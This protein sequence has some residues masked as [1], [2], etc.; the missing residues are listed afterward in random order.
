MNR[1]IGIAHLTKRFGEATILEDFSLSLPCRGLVCVLGPSGCGKSTLLNIVAG[2]DT[3]YQGTVRVL[4]KEWRKLTPSR[5]GT[6]RLR[7]IGYV[8]QNFSLLELES[9]EANVYAVADALYHSK[10]QDK[11]RKVMDLLA[12]FG[13]EGK[14][15]QKVNTLSGGEKQRVALARALVSDPKIILADEPTGALDQKRGHEVFSLLQAC[16]KDRLVIIVT[17]DEELAE[18]YADEMVCL[19]DGKITERRTMLR[20]EKGPSPKSFLLTS[21]KT[22]PRLSWNFLFGHAVRLFRAKKWRSLISEGA[23]SLGLSGLGIATYISTSIS[24]ELSDAFSSL[25]PPNTVVM[26]PRGGSDSPVGAVYGAGIDDCEYIVGEY[27]DLVR[28]YGSDLH[29]DYEGWFVDRN[30]FSYQSGVE[31]VR[32]P[33]FSIRSINDYRWLDLYPSLVCYPRKPA[34]L[35][36]DQV[37]LGLPYENMFTMCLSL[38]I[39]RDYQSLGEYIDTHRLDLCLSIA[40]YAIGFDDE[41][42][43]RVVAV[44]ESPVPCFYHY[45]HHWNHH[46]IIDQ[47]HFRSSLSEDVPNPQYV[48]EIPFVSVQGAKEEFLSLARRDPALNHLVYEKENAGYSPTIFRDAS[49]DSD[50]I[51]LYGCDKSGVSFQTLDECMDLCPDILGR[52]PVTTGSYFAQTG[53]LAM[54]FSNLFFLCKDPS[55]VDEVMDAYSDL[56]LES[57]FLPGDEIAGSKSG[58]C[59]SLGNGLRL[60]SLSKNDA[61]APNGIEECVLTSGLYERWGRPKE[62]FVVA[63]IGAEEVGSSYVRNLASAPMKVVGTVDRDYDTLYVCDDWTVDFYFAQLGVSS[64]VLEPYGAVF[65]LAEGAEA[66]QSVTKLEK[67][68][69]SYE[70]TN[71]SEDIASSIETTLGYVGTILL[72]FSFIALAMSALL[73]LIVMT[74]TISESQRDIGLFCILGLSESDVRNSFIAQCV[75]YGFFAGVSSVFMVLA[76]ELLTQVYLSRSFGSMV[77]LR[78]SWQPL[79]V[80]ALAMVLFTV[81]VMLGISINLHVKI[82]EKRIQSRRKRLILR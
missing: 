61:R 6:L 80:I 50:R 71:P 36:D 27:G 73:F 9:A 44:V 20:E 58:S 75:L 3:N 82:V 77:H 72:W 74:I 42:L 78:L 55:V 13:L 7:N 4:G 67:A 29:L 14:A 35:Y 24:A 48:F 18:A 54:G 23:I 32:L 81:I 1:A 8:F 21:A 64:F 41:E 47:L 19:R 45:D 17:H 37:V 25:V 49:Y 51:Y 30:D 39:L 22:N 56:P 5:R 59:F 33:D 63:E 68:F 79:L 52:Q 69:P 62:V 12:F 46:V 66:K 34:I 70:F 53:S 57:A 26:M 10:K 31:R 11:H 60:S 15:K 28:D 38:H 40:N 65:F 16:S 43:Y 76:S 2:I